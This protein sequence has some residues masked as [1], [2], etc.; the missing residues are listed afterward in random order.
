MLEWGSL[1]GEGYVEVSIRGT[2]G[3]WR[4]LAVISDGDSGDSDKLGM[5]SRMTEE[6]G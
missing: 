2:L 4:G 3:M 6:K 5:I 1:G